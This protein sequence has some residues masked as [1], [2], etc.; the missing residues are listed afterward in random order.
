MKLT[1]AIDPGA[2]GGIAWHDG[3]PH[4]EPMPATD[5]DVRKL[6]SRVIM[7][8]D[9]AAT[10]CY[11]EKV[12]GFIGGVGS[13]GSAMFNFGFGAGFIHGVLSAYEVPVVE[14]RPQAWQKALA[15]GS[16]EHAKAEKGQMLTPAEKKAMAARNAA[17]KNDWKN[18]LKAEAQRRYPALNVTLKT[19]DAL[20]ILAAA[21][22]GKANG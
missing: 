19:A 7:A 9:I 17:Y 18:K 13:P 5:T 16:R 1:I 10:D 14:V 22:E 15:L 3:L 2:S 6:I 20:L 21:M 4:C 11:I 12:G 8:G